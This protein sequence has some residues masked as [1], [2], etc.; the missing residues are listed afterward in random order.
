LRPLWYAG[1]FTIGAISGVLGDKWS[2]GFIEETE[3]QVSKHL[4]GHLERLPE[5]DM[6][7]RAIVEQMRDEE[8]QHGANANKAG[9][10]AL[11]PPAAVLMRAFARVM[12]RTAYRF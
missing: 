11:P 10:A 12:T 3:K 6:R 2:L 9:A 7:S 4:T 1:A 8:E 5:N